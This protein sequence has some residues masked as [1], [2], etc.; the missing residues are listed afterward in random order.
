MIHKYNY[1][2]IILF[3]GGSC[4]NA[5][6]QNRDNSFIHDF[7]ITS[8]MGYVID[9][10]DWLTKPKQPQPENPNVNKIHHGWG[11]WG[12]IKYNFGKKNNNRVGFL[13][14]KAIIKA[15]YSDPAPALFQAIDFVTFNNFEF[16]YGRMLSHKRSNFLAGIGFYI[17]TQK[18]VLPNERTYQDSS[19]NYY[20]VIESYQSFKDVA[21]GIDLYFDYA[22]RINSKVSIGLRLKVNYSLYWYI[23]S[24]MLTPFIEI[25]L[26]NQNIK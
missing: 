1:L 5:I 18:T 25:G 23:E 20:T 4:N 9:P 2:L 11:A 8:G 16:S 17:S 22:Y 6:A 19:N 13:F 24:A 10:D 12:S 7:Y 3:I 21:P 15:Y 26:K 14:S